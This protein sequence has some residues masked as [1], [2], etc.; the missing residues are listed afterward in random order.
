[1]PRP[2]IHETPPPRV[3]GS[4]RIYVDFASGEF[5]ELVGDPKNCYILNSIFSR[6][7][8]VDTLAMKCWANGTRFRTHIDGKRIEYEVHGRVVVKVKEEPY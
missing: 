4:G 8:F 6:G 2:K 1:M 3:A 5:L 7:Q